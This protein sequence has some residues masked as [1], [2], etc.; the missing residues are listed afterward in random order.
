LQPLQRFFK[1]LQ[2]SV[3]RLDRN[4]LPTA[5]KPL[6]TLYLDAFGLGQGVDAALDQQAHHDSRDAA[7]DSFLELVTKLNESTFKPLLG[8]LHDW[9]LVQSEEDGE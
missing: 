2:R 7:I 9:A 4:A 6:F 5:I 1:L 8:R 3:R